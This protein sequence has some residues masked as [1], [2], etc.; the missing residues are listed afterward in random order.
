MQLL[1]RNYKK[2]IRRDELFENLLN[3]IVIACLLF[4]KPW[5][6]TETDY[7]HPVDNIYFQ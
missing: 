3:L 6:I 4:F 5:E 2:H 1:I 7:F